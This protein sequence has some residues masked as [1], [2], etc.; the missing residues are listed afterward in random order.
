VATDLGAGT[1]IVVSAPVT[2]L[3]ENKWVRIS[4]PTGQTPQTALKGSFSRFDGTGNY[5]LL[6]SLYIP[7]GTGA[8]TVQFEPFGEG[9][10]SYL[11][12]M[13]LDFMPEGD[14]RIDDSSVRFG[15]FL[16]DQAFALSVN[17]VITATTATARITLFGTGVGEHRRECQPV[18][19]RGGSQVWGGE[20]LDGVSVTGV[21]L[22]G[23]HPGHAPELVTSRGER[24]TA[25]P[26]EA[27]RVDTHMA[28]AN[29]F[30]YFDLPPLSSCCSSLFGGSRGAVSALPLGSSM[31]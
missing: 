28:G 1:V 19:T 30:S 7:S 4:H 10:T 14:V 3:P 26:Q 24:L 21:V 2:G 22:R 31:S 5:T 29:T 8:V 6:A 16:R 12:F 23:R 18:I 17:L 13:H 9:P 11:N 25:R 20:I 27:W 15:Q